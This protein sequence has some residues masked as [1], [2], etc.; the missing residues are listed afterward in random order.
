MSLVFQSSSVLA[1]TP[2]DSH[3]HTPNHA[4]HDIHTPPHLP[5]STHTPHDHSSHYPK[6]PIPQAHLYH[7]VINLEGGNSAGIPLHCVQTYVSNQDSTS[8][9]IG[10]CETTIFMS[11][12]EIRGNQQSRAESSAF[13]DNVL[14][15]EF[16]PRTRCMDSLAMRLTPSS[17]Y[18]SRQSSSLSRC[19]QAMRLTPSSSYQSRQGSSLSRH[20]QKAPRQR[21]NT[22]G[23]P[24]TALV[25]LPTTAG[26]GYLVLHGLDLADRQRTSST[27]Q[28]RPATL[29]QTNLMHVQPASSADMQNR[30]CEMT[31]PSIRSRDHLRLHLP[32][33]MQLHHTSKELRT[34]V[35]GEEMSPHRRLSDPRPLSG[36][37]KEVCRTGEEFSRQNTSG[38]ES[39]S[40]SDKRGEHQNHYS[41]FQHDYDD[42]SRVKEILEG[43]SILL[44]FAG[45]YLHIQIATLT[46]SQEKICKMTLTQSRDHQLSLQ[47]AMQL[48]HTFM[49]YSNPEEYQHHYHQH[50]HDHDYDPKFQFAPKGTL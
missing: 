15:T 44:S 9:S 28:L 37:P 16:E 23:Q 36:S 19:Y 34:V 20:Y 8:A 33:A 10:A 17:G 29:L 18:Q 6:E 13:G 22:E 35:P 32:G 50:Q 25:Q 24:V 2:N 3:S 48:Q 14:L 42:V 1:R 46:D 4:S 26:G 41:Q 7:Q 43:M 47:G 30:I 31:P 21:H 39:T 11:E 49:E 27:S 40:N 45:T 38:A 5:H 12:Q